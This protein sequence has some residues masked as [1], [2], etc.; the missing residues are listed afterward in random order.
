MSY[1]DYAPQDARPPQLPDDTARPDLTPVER[2]PEDTVL[3]MDSAKIVDT[4]PPDQP[5]PYSIRPRF[6]TLLLTFLVHHNPF[7]LISALCMIAGCY[8]LN[9]GLELRTGEV[10][11]ILVLIGTLTV[12]ELLL[13]ALGLFLIRGRGILRDGRTLLLL[14]IVFLVDL[15]FL[16][17]ETVTVD[18]R[19]GL[20]VNGVLLLLAL[21]KV[22]AVMKWLTPVFP[23]RSFLMAGLMLTALFA[24]PCVLK[25]VEFDGRVAGRDLHAIWWCV[26]LLPVACEM[27]RHTL[28]RDGETIAAA[29]GGTSPAPRLQPMRPRLSNVYISMGFASV[30]AH[31][32][33]MHW[34]YQGRFYAADL[35]PVLLGLA[36]A[37]AYG[38]PTR[39]V[40]AGDLR[41][42][43]QW[44]PIAAILCALAGPRPLHLA[45]GLDGRFEPTSLHLAIAGAMAV[46]FYAYFWKWV[47]VVGVVSAATALLLLFGPTIRQI[48]AACVATWEQC[49]AIGWQI[50]PKTLLQWGVTAVGAAFAFLG[51]GALLSLSQP[52]QSPPQLPPESNG[53]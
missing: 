21:L 48:Q 4:V 49:L 38:S 50:M 18:L 15:T 40:P 46:Y 42:A 20:V 29:A 8:V 13:V 32:G 22:G 33:M 23:W 7:Y 26:G 44:L 28:R 16:N 2:S 9:I 12:Y 17:A 35:T 52:R 11:R 1:N 43:R 14:Q 34:V 31:L 19:M 24:L 27:I 51:I 3:G 47:R 41:F 37:A 39:V 5:P 10:H 45:I 36:V 6:R 25:M 53:A 30:I